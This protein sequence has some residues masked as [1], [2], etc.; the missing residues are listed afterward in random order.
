M[1]KHDIDEVSVRNRLDHF[2]I[3]I[4]LDLFGRLIPDSNRPRTGIPGKMVEEFFRRSELTID[5]VKNAQARPR[6]PRCV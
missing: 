6:Q 3:N 2:A 1:N 4:E 5:I